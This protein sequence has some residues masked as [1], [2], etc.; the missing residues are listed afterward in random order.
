MVKSASDYPWSSYSFFIGK[1]KVPKWLEADWLLSQFGRNLK[2][3]KRNY[4]SFGSELEQILSKGKKRNSARD[5]AI[6]LARDLTGMGGKELGEI[7][8]N[9]SGAAITMRHKAVSDK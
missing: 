9:V 8:G 7:Y 5:V 6:Y 2:E 3:A 4:K 1:K